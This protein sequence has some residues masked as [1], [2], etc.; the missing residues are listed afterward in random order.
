MAEP[1]LPA[2]SYLDASSIPYERRSFPET[3]EKGGANVAA[4]LGYTED[5]IVKTLIFE[6]GAGERVLVMVGSNRSAISGLLKKAIGSRNIKMA[7]FE[8]VKQTTGYEVGSIPP[9]HWQPDGFRSFLDEA[10]TRE[11]TL[12]VG[13]GQWGEEILI[14]PDNLLRACRGTVVNLT[15]RRE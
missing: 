14:T 1:I 9:F 10:L 5:Q 8:S 7:S 15:E 13:A 11:E 6:T 4:A 2:H 3:T 12:G